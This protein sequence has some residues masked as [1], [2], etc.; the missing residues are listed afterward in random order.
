MT[1]LDAIRLIADDPQAEIVLVHGAWHGPWCWHEGFAQRLAERGISST[2]VGLRGHGGSTDGV[3]LNRM[4]MRDYIDDV[5]AVLT[6]LGLETPP[7]VAGHSMGGAVV[8]GMLARDNRPAIAGAALLASMPPRGVIGVTIDI[9]IRRPADF[10][11]GNL[12]LDLGLLVRRP[13]DVRHLFFRPE[14][15]QDVVDLTT[16]NV[17]SESYRAF[18]DM[19]VLDRPKPRPVDVPL[20]VLGAQEDVIFPPSDVFATACAWGTEPVMLPSLGHDVMLDDGWERVADTL[21]DWVLAH[22]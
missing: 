13:E 9:A 15:S 3:T 1:A 11:R 6:G 10:L 16:A 7:F 14:T 18:L 20:L 19:L 5:V 21:A 17:K 12:T 2:A 4:R 22:A 8:Q